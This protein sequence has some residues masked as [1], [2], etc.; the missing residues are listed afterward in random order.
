MTILPLRNP[1]CHRITQIRDNTNSKHHYYHTS[2]KKC[3]SLVISA[4]PA[5]HLPRQHAQEGPATR[6]S[7]DNSTKLLNL[8]HLPPPEHSG[9]GGTVLNELQEQN[10]LIKAVLPGEN[11]SAERKCPGKRHNSGRK[12]TGS[13]KTSTIG[14][15]NQEK[16]PL[17]KNAPR[18]AKK[19]GT[20]NVPL[21]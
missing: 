10:I 18:T 15:Q 4:L 2:H 17:Q 13:N 11:A 14:P 12:L 5:I 21:N 16:T 6:V 19:S 3:D 8:P 20:P 9:S 7:V 1:H